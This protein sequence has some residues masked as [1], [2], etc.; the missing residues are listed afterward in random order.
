MN[1]CDAEYFFDKCKINT[2][3]ILIMMP[4]CLLR[5]DKKVENDLQIII[6]HNETK[7][8]YLSLLWYCHISYLKLTIVNYLINKYIIII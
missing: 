6:N 8:G 2:E 1:F 5:H 3:S 4:L 7:V